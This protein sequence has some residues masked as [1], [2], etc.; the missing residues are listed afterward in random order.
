VV[1]GAP[2]PERPSIAALPFDN[3]GGDPQQGYLADGIAEDLTTDLTKLSSLFVSSRN[4]VWTCKVGWQKRAKI[5]AN[6]KS[7]G[8]VT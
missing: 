6:T 7:D 8:N 2:S 5:T 3:L 4:A 1:E